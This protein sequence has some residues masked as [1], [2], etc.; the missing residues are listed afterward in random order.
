MKK[1]LIEDITNLLKTICEDAEFNTCIH[2]IENNKL[3]NLRLFVAEKYELLS[4]ISELT[5]NDAV[6]ST[7]VIQC[8]TLENLVMD[9]YLETV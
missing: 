4:A 7:Q 3:N 2:Y 6:L 9:A 8:D 1:Q 5:P